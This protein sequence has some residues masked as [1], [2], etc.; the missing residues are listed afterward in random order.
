LTLQSGENAAPPEQVPARIRSKLA[1]Y[2]PER[3]LVDAYL[4]EIAK[5]YGVDW[6]PEPPKSESYNPPQADETESNGKTDGDDDDEPGGGVKERVKEALAVPVGGK[7]KEGDH[8]GGARSGT[9]PQ[10]KGDV[11]DAWAKG[12]PVVAPAPT[13]KLTPEEELAQRFERLKKL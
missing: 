8:G 13:K 1:L 12:A 10:D 7:E 11:P 4:Y 2:I 3:E 6:T 5:G 9:S